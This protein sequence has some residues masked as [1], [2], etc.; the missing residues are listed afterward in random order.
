VLVALSVLGLLGVLVVPE[1]WLGLMGMVPIFFGIRGWY[2]SET[3]P[4]RINRPS[5]PGFTA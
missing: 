2:D 3:N 4:R 5:I 1:G